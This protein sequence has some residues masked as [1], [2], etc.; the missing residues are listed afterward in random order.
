MCPCGCGQ[1]RDE[2]HDPESDGWWEVDASII[3]QAGAALE[4][5]RRAQKEPVPGVLPVVRLSA[6]HA[7]RAPVGGPLEQ[8][9]SDGE[10]ERDSGGE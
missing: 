4:T 7:G 5:W 10:H 2:A 3:C 1:F 8:T 9:E 6:E